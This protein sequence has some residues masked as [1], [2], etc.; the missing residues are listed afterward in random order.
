M[1]AT[2]HLVTARDWARLRP[3]LSP[4]L[5]RGFK[6]SPYSKL[7]A[8]VDLSELLLYGRE[9][10]SG[11]PRSR[12]ELA[13]LLA[14]RCPGIDPT[15]LAYA[16]SY[17]EP[18]V[19]VPPRGLSRQSGQAR[20]MSASGWLDSELEAHRRPRPPHA[21]LPGRRL[22]CRDLAAGGSNAARP[23]NPPADRQGAARCRQRS[24]ATRRFH[25]HRAP[26]TPRPG[27]P[28]RQASA[29]A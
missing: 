21:D 12:A 10:V 18:I 24:R 15:A 8:G 28:T 19:Q 16:V 25:C 3:L 2:L 23:A 6:A 14:D 22:R 29:P 9:L 13:P 7:I 4:V 26:H 11:R 27:A 1:R 17:L 5:A 20:W